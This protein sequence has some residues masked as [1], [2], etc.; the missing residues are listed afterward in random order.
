MIDSIYIDMLTGE[1]FKDNQ[2]NVLN[3][4]ARGHIGFVATDGI[5]VG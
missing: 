3:M 4:I 5:I 1:T 2:S